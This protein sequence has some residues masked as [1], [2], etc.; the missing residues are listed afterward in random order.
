MYF[1]KHVHRKDGS[2]HEVSRP[3]RSMRSMPRLG[4]CGIGIPV[5]EDPE[6]ARDTCHAEK[7]GQHG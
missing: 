6:L 2:R 1:T 4:P 3:E 5:V 7:D